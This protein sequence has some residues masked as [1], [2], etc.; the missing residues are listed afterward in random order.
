MK[1]LFLTLCLV[2][3]V[4]GGMNAGPVDQQRAQ[5]LGAKLMGNSQLRLAA[6]VS[7]RGVADYYA[8]N[9]NNGEGFVIVAADDR[10]KPILAYSTTGRFDPDRVSEGFQFTL[11]SFFL[12]YENDCESN[13]IAEIEP[14]E[15]IQIYPNPTNG[16]L[17]VSGNG[18]M[19]ITVS[20]LIGQIIM[21]VNAKGYTI[22][23]LSS[24]RSGIGLCRK[25][26]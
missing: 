1:K 3:V 4:I 8:F 23:D 20:N 26:P 22:L 5:Q 21:D 2:A 15:S 24:N 18:M 16:L 14:D 7:D 11:N 13:D 9:V 19:H 10:V 25:V 17:N 12:T 6:T